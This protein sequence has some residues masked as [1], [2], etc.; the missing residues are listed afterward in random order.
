MYALQSST[1]IPNSTLP[2]WIPMLQCRMTRPTPYCAAGF[3]AANGTSHWP[4]QVRSKQYH[5]HTSVL[6][7]CMK[8]SDVLTISLKTHFLAA[9]FFFFCAGVVPGTLRKKSVTAWQVIFSIAFMMAEVCLM[10]K[11]RYG[12]WPTYSCRQVCFYN[13]AA[14]QHEYSR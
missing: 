9:S 7:D 6:L 12:S 13:V 1:V 2:R 10:S 5:A 8:L 3:T 14:S 4:G 11:L